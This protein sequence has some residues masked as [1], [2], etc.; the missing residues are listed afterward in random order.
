MTCSVVF[1]Q[2]LITSLLILLFFLFLL[3]QPC[4]KRA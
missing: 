1:S 3:G 4:S 2:E